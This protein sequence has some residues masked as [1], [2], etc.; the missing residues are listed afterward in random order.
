MKL[1]NWIVASLM[2]SVALPVGQEAYSQTLALE[3]IVVTARKRDENIYEIPV[4]VSALTDA[5]LEEAGIDNAQDLSAFIPGLDFRQI[6]FGG[7]NN[8][9]IRVRGM[10]QQIITPSTQI[11]A[12]FYDGSYVGGGGGFLPIGDVERV[13]VIKGPQTAYF[14]RN[15]FAGA[16][17]YIPK[18]PGDEWEGDISL[19]W[20]P[21][22]HDEYNFNAGIGGPIGSRLGIRVWAG[23][24]RDGGDF[25]FDDGEP[26]GRYTDTSVNGTLVYD[27]TEDLRIKVNGY[28]T[29]SE[30]TSVGIGVKAPVPAGSCGIIYRGQLLNVV[31]GERTPFESDLS[32]LRV[33]NFC[34]RFPNSPVLEFPAT[35]FPT[36][37][38][39]FGGQRRVDSLSAVNPRSE[40][41]SIIRDPQGGLGGWHQTYRFQLSAEYDIADHTINLLASRASTG[42]TTR[43]DFFYGIPFLSFVSPDTMYPIGTEIAVR[44]FYYEAR[45]SSPQDQRFRWL[46]GLSAYNQHYNAFPDSSRLTSAIDRQ[47]S[48]TEGVFGSLDYDIT[49]DI[50]LSIEGRYQ[51]EKFTAVEFGNPTLPC[52]IVFICNETNAYDAFL[53]R[54]ILSYAPMDGAT[55]YVSWSQSKLLG[56]A[57]QAAYINSIAPDVIPA[58]AVD[59]FGN[60]TPPQKNT[61][62]E[63]GWKQQ[64]DNWNMTL[65]IFYID[66]NNQ[67]FPAVI[68]LPTGGTSSFR[69]PGD[70]EYSGFDFEF[71]GQITEWFGISGQM[72]YSNGVMR[73]YSNFGSN[74]RV[75]LAAPGVVASDGNPVRGHPEWTGSLSPVITGTM[76]DR[77][78]FIRTDV[79]YTSKYFTDY[80]KYNTNPSRMDVNVRAGMTLYEGM[81]IE[82]YGNNIFNDKT[83]PTTAG[84]TTAFNH[85]AGNAARKIF[86]GMPI[87]LEYGIRLKASF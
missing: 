11:G 56:L 4:S 39:T 44:E 21:T 60:F 7:R 62:Y 52:G 14:G 61:Q 31:T 20:S 75:G 10:I 79:L 63:W 83:L 23:Y 19:S 59:V 66:W 58:E 6:G 42:T 29:E 67:P 34:G 35:R 49:D 54:V 24:D 69:G 1:R 78:W 86:S 37:A 85:A 87:A 16:I 50:T 18:L 33:D 5:M 9:N 64:W 27:A 32:Q 74:E 40:D 38:N 41:F 48:V 46:L 55:T 82:L 81:D 84:T 73:D 28:Y 65:A 76:L 57:T 71:S 22:D 15:T 36:A 53:P 68:F 51:E 2:A 45:V 3:E 80:S 25:S 26:F 77:D 8:A 72:A 30:D 47:R 13:E 12:L 17:N 70:S 43:V